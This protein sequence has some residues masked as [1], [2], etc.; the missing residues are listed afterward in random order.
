MNS[1]PIGTTPTME[2]CVMVDPKTNYLPAMKEEANR[3]RA[4][5]L[6]R[7]SLFHL[8]RYKVRSNPH[9]FGNYIDIEIEYD[10]SC[11]KST[12]QAFFIERNLPDTWEDKKT[13]P[14]IE[15]CLLFEKAVNTLNLQEQF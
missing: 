15:A 8:V 12:D 6:D 13:F 2:E 10:N 4:M 11:E 5:L 3:F 9:D 1:I 7:F 14:E